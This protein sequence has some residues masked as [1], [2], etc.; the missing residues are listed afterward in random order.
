MFPTLG[1]A[2]HLEKSMRVDRLLD[3]NFL[4]SAAQIFFCKSS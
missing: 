3:T 4:I 1:R 2:W